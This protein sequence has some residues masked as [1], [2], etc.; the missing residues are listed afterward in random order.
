VNTLS[1][2]PAKAG[3]FDRLIDRA[4]T[5][6]ERA[7]QAGRPRI[8]DY[9]PTGPDELR[10]ILVRE[11]IALDAEYRRLAGERPAPADYADR[12]PGLDPAWLARVVVLPVD[13]T[14]VAIT[15][16]ATTDGD[17]TCA[18]AGPGLAR[19]GDYEILGELGRGGMGIV[20]KAR[21]TKLNRIVALKVIR[22][23]ELA[24]PAEAQRFRAEAENV[25][26]LDHP[27]IVP[28]YEVGEYD[29]LPFL[30]MKVLEG[31]SLAGVGRA[32][33]GAQP[34]RAAEVVAT[35][36]RAVHH[37]HQRGIL[38]RDLKPGNIL[39]DAQGQPHVTDFGLAKRVGRAEG[40]TQTGTVLGTPNYMAPEQASGHGKQ[41]TLAA[42]VYALGAILYEL[43]TGR[44]PFVGESVAQTLLKVIHQEPVPPSRLVR[45]VPR[46][47]EAVCL[48]CLEKDP[49]RRYTSAEGLADDLARWLRG[50]PTV[51]RRVGAV[52]RAWRWCR[53]N[54]V[55]AGLLALLIVATAAA[56][57]FAVVAR[58]HEGLAEKRAT[59]AATNLDLAYR[60]AYLSDMRLAPIA[61]QE[62]RL[63]HLVELLEGQR[64]ERTAGKDLRGFEWHYWDRLAHSELLSFQ[65]PL[66]TG[67]LIGM[68]LSR[69][70]HWLATLSDSGRVHV[71]DARTGRVARVLNVE[72]VERLA[73]HPEGRLLALASDRGVVSVIDLHTG[74]KRS[75][76]Q[77]HTNP[78]RTLGFAP[79]G[80]RIGS[81]DAHGN[82]KFCD[83]AT[84]E[85]LLTFL[86]EKSW[87]DFPPVASVAFG[88]GRVAVVP[89]AGRG[90]VVWEIDTAKRVAF[91]G[92]KPWVPA[93]SRDGTMI[94]WR[95]LESAE[96]VLCDLAT[97][98]SRDVAQPT[99][100]VASLVFGPRNQL[101]AFTRSERVI[102]VL[103]GDQVRSFRGLNAP[104]VG[105]AFD[106]DGRLF[107]VD[108]RGEV[109]VWDART[110]PER[111]SFPVPTADHPPT[112]LSTDGRWLT[113]FIYSK[114]AA[115][116]AAK[117][118]RLSEIWDLEAEKCIHQLPWEEEGQVMNLRH[119]Y[120]PGSQRLARSASFERQQGDPLRIFE[121]WDLGTGRRTVR[122]ETPGVLQQLAFSPDGQTVVSAADGKLTARDAV[123]GRE[124]RDWGGLLP[125]V[126]AV[127]FSPDG[128]RLAGAVSDGQTLVWEYPG[129]RLLHSFSHEQDP[130]VC[131]AFDR[132]GRYLAT[133]STSRAVRV[134]D[135][136]TGLLVRTLKGHSQG[137]HTVAFHPTEPR[138]ASGSD[139]GT[140][141]V[142]DLDSGQ[143]ILNLREQ[144]PI[145]AVAFT[146][147]G[148]KLV[149]ID[150][151]RIR[152]L[153]ASPR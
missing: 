58:H 86:E 93:L 23:G 46:D 2:V 51:A 78:I 10:S 111:F 79:D 148:R 41:V 130:V 7:W 137:V 95:A 82:L 42:D 150:W 112:T 116:V 9:L 39:L 89:D 118:R 54:P 122:I 107:G 20:Y 92:A 120:H 33:A 106:A 97:R 27:N 4:L 15:P 147:D 140:L 94:A 104:P 47:L 71:L 57:Y 64:P 125:D 67:A 25:A 26:Q 5:G 99:L 143:E 11:L 6:F 85:E 50:E 16:E 76:Y 81:A 59:E 73:V 48:K 100:Q 40:Q 121:V 3:E 83:P 119:T 52:G 146:P 65:V 138:L 49:Q 105:V 45:T 133:G 88:G 124:V 108:T 98:K 19:C 87:T 145:D 14:V 115:N 102:A 110:N 144:S 69:D 29:G 109:R 126:H 151:K 60:R 131:V 44:P 43:L 117:R 30:T 12:F 36:A 55:V 70:G 66:T 37:A 53:R 21:H 84:G 22:G 38:H 128:R 32:W 68:D 141:R 1:G 114:P 91:L 153:D 129:G 61:W 90:V 8:E 77:A 103:E 72:G 62:N 75:E 152:I 149:S 31:G 132:Q 28:V 135:L 123:T 127:C 113:R 101:A 139:D 24:S 35:L 96:I 17:P 56:M 80:T 13:A 134:W 18:G 34:R 142:W 63:D 74:E 136:D